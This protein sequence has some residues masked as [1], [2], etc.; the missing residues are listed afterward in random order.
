[1]M[2]LTCAITFI[3]SKNCPHYTTVGS[4]CQ[5]FFYFPLIISYKAH[6]K[7]I[8]AIAVDKTIKSDIIYSP[9]DMNMLRASTPN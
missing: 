3:L 6:D 7:A 2:C 1:M 5:V 9:P 4:G 8:K